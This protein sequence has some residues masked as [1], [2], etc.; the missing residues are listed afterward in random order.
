MTGGQFTSDPVFFGGVA[1]WFFGGLVPSKKKIIEIDYIFIF[2]QFPIRT[3]DPID[4][5][6][7]TTKSEHNARSYISY[8]DP[9]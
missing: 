5:D 3:S 1:C 2:S 9:V 4:S 6:K 8:S 7:R